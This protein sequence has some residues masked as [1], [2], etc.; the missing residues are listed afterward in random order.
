MSNL[1]ILAIC[2]YIFPNGS[3]ID[4]QM[5]SA[6]VELNYTDDMDRMA[7]LGRLLMYS[8]YQECPCFPKPRKVEI[9]DRAIIDKRRLTC[10][11]AHR[12]I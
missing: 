2:S 9:N 8:S 3:A 1:L 10:D 4:Y 11:Q 7:R 12:M 5:C 6:L